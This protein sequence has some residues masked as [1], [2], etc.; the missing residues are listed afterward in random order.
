MNEMHSSKNRKNGETTSKEMTMK[1]M[2]HLVVDNEYVSVKKDSFGEMS[3]IQRT[4]QEPQVLSS[5]S[6]NEVMTPSDTNKEII[7]T[8]AITAL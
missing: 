5:S 3:S 6:E 8:S 4:F 1:N 2:E 7:S